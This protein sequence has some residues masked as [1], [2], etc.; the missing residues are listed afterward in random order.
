MIFCLIDKILLLTNEVENRIYKKSP[1]YY[2]KY[3]FDFYKNKKKKKSKRI[4]RSQNEKSKAQS[5]QRMS[6]P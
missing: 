6:Y 4:V 5:H 2:K 1:I 3:I